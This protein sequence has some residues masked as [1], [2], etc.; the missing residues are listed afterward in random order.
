MIERAF[1]FKSSGTSLSATVC[2]PAESG[3][4]PTVLMIH[5]SGP[6]DRNEN[7]K[8]QALDV[9]NTLARSFANHGIASLRY[10]KRGCGE[11]GGK[12][13]EAGHTDFVIDAAAGFEALA[14]QDFCDPGKIFL[15]GHSEGC[16]IAP[17]VAQRKASAGLIL[18]CPFIENIESVLIRQSRQIE[19]E[20][21]ALTGLG[22]KVTRFFLKRMGMTAANQRKLLDKIKVSSKPT[23]WAGFQR[24]PAKWLRELMAVNTEAVYRRVTVPMLLVGGEKDMQ[25]RPE[26][27]PLIAAAA[28]VETEEHLI[29]DLTHILR[30]DAGPPTL[31]GV[32]K[33]LDKPIEPI[34]ASLVTE[35]IT[36][37]I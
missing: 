19:S 18:L 11:S 13:L 9:F 21:D 20:L 12:F 23:V 10:D 15:L 31:L 5:G 28:S 7:V 22:G 27:V 33:L 26:D 8:G 3:R 4:F 37:R 17:Q 29:A 32:R 6:V 2:L 36:K 30:F 14:H 16:I 1:V 35:W 24:V 34:V 25:C